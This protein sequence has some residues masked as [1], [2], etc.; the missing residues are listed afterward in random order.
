MPVVISSFSLGRRST[1]DFV[2]RRALAH[3]RDELGIGERAHHR[4]LIGEGMALDGDFDAAAP[5]RRPVRHVEC[6][7]LVIVENAQPH[8]RL[9]SSLRVYAIA[10]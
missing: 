5:Y 1:T 10:L 8:R 7:T 9:L 2:K 3:R 6:D 4:V